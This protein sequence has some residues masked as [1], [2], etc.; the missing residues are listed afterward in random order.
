MTS[1]P[2][3]HTT[4]DAFA[5]GFETEQPDAAVVPGVLLMFLRW[6]QGRAEEIEPVLTQMLADDVQLPGLK[7][8]LA[9]DALRERQPRR[10]ARRGGR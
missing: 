9:N 6:A 10:G 2:P 3:R 8:G 5:L 7:A 1:M 4:N